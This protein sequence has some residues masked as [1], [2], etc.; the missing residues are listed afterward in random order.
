MPLIW[1]EQPGLPCVLIGTMPPAL[2]QELAGPMVQGLGHVPDLAA[3]LGRLRLTVAPLRF[4]AGVKG[5]VLDSLTARTPCVTTRVAADSIGLPPVL[6]ALISDDPA[7]L[8]VRIIRQH[9]GDSAH[10]AAVRAGVTVVRRFH[11][12]AGV[13]AALS[14]ALSHSI[15]AA[16][17]A[18]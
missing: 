13:K 14:A 11:S 17:A 12:D 15:M 4:R 16:R 18:G 7:G 3:E 1:A 8:A 6:Q 9:R 5:K 2:V 10:R